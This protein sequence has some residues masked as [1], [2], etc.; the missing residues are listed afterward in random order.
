MSLRIRVLVADDHGIVAEALQQLLGTQSDLEV[1]GSA[2]TG[3]EAV[4]RAR[5]L[6]PDVVLMDVAMPE[7]NGIEAARQIRASCPRCRVVI[8][9]MYADGEHVHR[10]LQAGASGYVLK[11]S[12]ARETVGAIRAAHRGAHFLSSELAGA[13]AAARAAGGDALAQLSPRERQ[14]L[15]LLAEGKSGSQIG[16]RLSLSPKTVDTYRSRLAE[17][18]GI[19]D[20]PGLVRFAIQHGVI[21]LEYGEPGPE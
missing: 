2:A 1:V 20:L 11:K 10:A 14:V 9:S 6:A 15:Q 3:V 13:V 8:L 12:A 17:K 4:Q 21:P 19:H 7:L 16:E 5:E 18:L